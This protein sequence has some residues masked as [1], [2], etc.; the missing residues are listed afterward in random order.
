MQKGSAK[1]LS[2][3]V[4]GNASSWKSINSQTGKRTDSLRKSTVADFN[5]LQVGAQKQMNQLQSGVIASAKD[6]AVGFGKEMGRMKGYANSAMGG[7]VGQLNRGITGIDSVLGQFG[8][9]NNVIKTIKYANGSNGKLATNQMAMIND[10][11]TGP[12]QEAVIRGNRWFL[13]KGNNRILPLQKGDQVLN[14]HQTQKLG[15]THYAKGSGVSDSALTKIAES[16]EKNPAATFAKD[17]TDKMKSTGTDLQKGSVDLEKNA[18]TRYGV[19]WTKAMFSV[20]NDE[21]NGGGSGTRAAVL[22]YAK[23]HFTGKPYRL[24]GRG[25][26]YYDCAAMVA[27]ALKHFGVDIGW[28][29]TAMQ[30]SSGVSRMG[31]NPAKT[32]PGDIVLWGHGTGAGGHVG[33]VDRPGTSSSNTITFNETPPR[34]R[35]TTVAYHTAL[36]LDGYYRIKALKDKKTASKSA[37]DQLKALAK[38]EL[39]S[40]SLSWISSNLGVSDSGSYGGTS[41]KP[42]G[43]HSH[44]MQQAGMPRSWWPAINEIV[45]AESSWQASARNGKYIGLPQTTEGNLAKAGSDWRT[46]PITQLKAMKMYIKGRYGTAAAALSFRHAHNW[47]ANGGWASG[48]SVFGEVPGEPEVAI[49]PARSSADGLINQ[50]IQA[51]AQVDKSSPSADFLKAAKS[52]KVSQ[53][54]RVIKPEIKININGDISDERMLK[55]TEDMIN[56]ALTSA[57]SKIDDEY[58]LDGS[59]Y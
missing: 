9:N 41:P 31:Q 7:A 55:K 35:D 1:Q 56:R 49:N 43:D 8:G 5:S 4:A 2:Q 16:G 23:E 22:K 53:V 47:Y 50:T 37:G 10:A 25:P 51:R 28:T 38:K 24:G 32:V 29:T 18:S 6:T 20:I 54:G 3:L 44:W 57:F 13:P 30:A 21:I 52:A 34:A 40:K 19:P 27:S 36:P 39:G 45:T 33:F 42:T 48:A 26:T 58:G 17:F 12:R 46:N 14:G 59:V 11:T 15:L